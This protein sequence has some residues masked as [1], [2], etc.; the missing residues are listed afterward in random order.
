MAISLAKNF[1]ENLPNWQRIK[2]SDGTVVKPSDTKKRHL[3]VPIFFV[4][5]EVEQEWTLGIKPQ[6]AVYFDVIP[7]TVAYL[8]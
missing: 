8:W 4:I 3:Q 7:A 2:L 5:E 1:V 6:E